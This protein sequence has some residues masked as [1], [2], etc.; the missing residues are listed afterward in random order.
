GNHD[1]S[2][3]IK[4]NTLLFE[5]E[6]ELAT[7]YWQEHQPNLN[8]VDPTHFPFYYSFKQ[9]DIFFLVWDASTAQISPKQLSWIEATLQSDQAQQAAARIVLG[10]L[11][12]Y[13]VAKRKNRPGEYLKDSQKLRSLLERNRVL[14]YVSGHHHVYY[15]GRMSKLLLFHAGALGQGERELITG[16]LLPSKTITAIDL[17]LSKS[18]LSYTTYNATT[19][20]Q[21]SME[22]LPSFIPSR[23]GKIWRH[24]L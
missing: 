6:R 10:H 1:G 9:N 24:D 3:A 7:A 19:W 11:P 8:F 12:F 5:Q 21:I 17:D 13:P 22:Q 18:E 15:P 16:G 14:M 20:Q 2:G 23:D 4:E